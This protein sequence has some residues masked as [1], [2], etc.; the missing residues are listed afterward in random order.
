MSKAAWPWPD[1]FDAMTAAPQYHVLLFENERVR[2]LDTRIPPGDI[3]P[4]HSHRWPA[5]YYTIQAGDFVRRDLDGKVLFDSRS[6]GGMLKSAAATWV[7][8][9]QPHSV[10]NVSG[11]EIHLVSIELKEPRA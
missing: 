7:E 10:E 5:L 9:L 6:V 8:P 2:V 1:S 3:V 11:S 4:A